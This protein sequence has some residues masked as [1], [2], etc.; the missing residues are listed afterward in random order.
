[1]AIDWLRLWHDMPNDPKFR[2]IAKATKQ[3]ISLVISLYVTL[4]VDASKNAMSRGVTECHDEDLAVTLDC[5][6]S[7]I[8]Q[9]KQAM[10]GR[11]LDGNYL[12][13]WEKR[14]PKREDAG[15]PETGAKSAAE[16]QRAKREREREALEQQPV[17]ECHDESRNVTLDKEKIKTKSK[18]KNSTFDAEVYLLGRGVSESVLVDWLTLRKT[19]RAPPTKTAIDDIEKEAAKVSMTLHDALVMGCRKG[20]A[21]FEAKWI[22][23]DKAICRQTVSDQRS[24]V[25][26]GLAGHSQQ[27]DAPKL[28]H[29]IEGESRHVA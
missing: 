23:N 17:T 26:A 24:A 6:M 5:D 19:K 25:Y 18:P 10:Q 22:Q 16:R 27:P 11:L 7:Q 12:T 29:V 2:V 1:M 13:G 28:E 4:L 9:I 15:D 21:G 8:E 14:Q 3:P 20:W